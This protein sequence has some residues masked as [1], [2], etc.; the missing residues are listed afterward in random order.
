VTTA[1]GV[2]GA[3]RSRLSPEDFQILGGLI[4]RACATEHRL[5]AVS[6]G[7]DRD[8]R[9]GAAEAAADTARQAV[10]AFL[11]QLLMAWYQEQ[12]VTR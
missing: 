3:A 4:S 8:T 10:H 9:L 2:Q 7:P 11:G 5:A 6:L 12:A 1:G